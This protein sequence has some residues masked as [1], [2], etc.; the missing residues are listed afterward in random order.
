MLHVPSVHPKVTLFS[1]RILQGSRKVSRGVFAGGG[2]SNGSVK[3]LPFQNPY[4]GKLTGPPCPS[5]HP[6]LDPRIWKIR[7]LCV[8][9]ITNFPAA[10]S[11]KFV[12]LASIVTSDFR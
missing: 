8:A 12:L 4:P 10:I 3:V 7:Y 11:K 2:G 6:T 9:F 5:S 1:D